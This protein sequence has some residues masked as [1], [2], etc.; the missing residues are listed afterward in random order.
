MDNIGDVLHGMRRKEL[1]FPQNERSAWEKFVD[2]GKEK[3]RFFVYRSHRM[4]NTAYCRKMQEESENRKSASEML[5]KDISR[6]GKNMK[7][8]QV[9]NRRDHSGTGNDD[10][11]RSADLAAGCEK[12]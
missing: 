8:R 1:C 6:G 11:R 2:N 10:C 3:V 12:R 9:E 4:G 5:K 7:K